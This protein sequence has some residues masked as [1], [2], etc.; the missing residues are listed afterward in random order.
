MIIAK[1]KDFF[2]K[3]NLLMKIRKIDIFPLFL[4]LLTFIPFIVYFRYYGYPNGDDAIWHKS[5]VFDLVY[6]WRNGFFGLNGGH[7][8]LGTSGYNIYLFYSP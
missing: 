3:D 5:Y 1:I 4:I 8:F 6:G 7:N 2:T